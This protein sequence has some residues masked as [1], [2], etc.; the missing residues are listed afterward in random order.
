VNCRRLSGEAAANDDSIGPEFR[1][2]VVPLVCH[3]VLALL[4]RRQEAQTIAWQPYN[5]AMGKG[6]HR[7][8][9]STGMIESLHA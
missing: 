1:F 3:K 6:I 7:K 2:F 8:V 5:N 9:E 4:M